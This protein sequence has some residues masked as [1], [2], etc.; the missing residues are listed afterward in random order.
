MYWC[1][2][3]SNT[4]EHFPT[5]VEN[6]FKREC[7]ILMIFIY[8]HIST[9]IKTYIVT[10]HSILKEE[11]YKCTRNLSWQ[12]MYASSERNNRQVS[13]SWR[14]LYTSTDVYYQK[15]EEQVT[16]P[17]SKTHISADILG[18]LWSNHSVLTK[19]IITNKH[20]QRAVTWVMG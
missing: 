13:C 19:N 20:K 11:M 14:V 6:I 3:N 2:I 16:Q 4:G 15:T 10:T 18:T 17:L 5:I 8:Y 7:W 12:L 9:F 1:H